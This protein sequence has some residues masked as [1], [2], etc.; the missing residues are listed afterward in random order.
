MNHL[1]RAVTVKSYPILS[2]EF[3]DGFIGYMDLSDKI[4]NGPMF[5]PLK[6]HNFFNTV[7]VTD[8]GHVFGWRLDDLGNEIDFLAE[9]ARIDIETAMVIASAANYRAH[10]TAAE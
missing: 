4:K 2:L 8:G 9:A 5:A 3:T 1:L 10:R 6:D 7:K